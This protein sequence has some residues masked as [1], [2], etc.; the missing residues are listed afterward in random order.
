MAV[1]LSRDV[2][3]SDLA[4]I[5]RLLDRV[6]VKDP[7]ARITLSQRKE[8]IERELAQLEADRATV[9]TVLLSF[10]GGPVRGSY[11]IDAD[12]AGRALQDYQELIAKQLAA[13]DSGGL[14][15]RG[16][17]PD[18]QVSR[19]NVTNVVHGSFGFLLEEDRE[20]EPQM[21]D[22]AVK[23]AIS[24]VSDL[25][26]TVTS[27]DPAGFFE[28]LD[29]VD[30]RVFI[31]LRKFIEDLYR[32]GSSM[33]VYEEDRALNFDVYA[34]NTARERMHAVEVTDDEITIDGE[35]LGIVPIQRRFDFRDRANGEIIKGK[36]GQRLSADYLERIHRD[37][38]TVGRHYRATMLRR[39]IRRADGVVATS[40][41]LLDLNDLTD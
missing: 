6:G 37:E 1:K 16:P 2:L 38:Q 22:S 10:E 9:G 17:V 8:V 19:L 14:A 27:P 13:S 29:S 21:F 11:A 25:F 15:Q 32:E 18:R 7:L 41:T 12:F 28:A 20:D 33:K 40:W 4:A 30:P 23:Q 3:Q 24:K 34:V 35:L 39:S 5:Q 36:V 31:S 26:S